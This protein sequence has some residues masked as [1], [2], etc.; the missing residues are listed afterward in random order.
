MQ[1]V[2]IVQ[3][4]R[5]PRRKLYAAIAVPMLIGLV[6]ANMHSPRMSPCGH[7]AERVAQIAA[8]RLLF[9][10]LP[11]WQQQTGRACPDVLTELTPYMNDHDARDIWGHD[12]VLICG[13]RG[14]AVI[15]TGEDGELGTDDDLVA[16][17]R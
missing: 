15:S 9:E 5:H 16:A 10:A 6:I 7:P 4:P 3:H 2:P 1:L 8:R 11:Q 17:T 12:Y 14:A 13:G